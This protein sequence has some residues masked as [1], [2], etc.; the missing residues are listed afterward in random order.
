MHLVVFRTM[1]YEQWRGKMLLWFL[2]LYGLARAVIDVWRGDFDQHLYVYG[3]T[4]TQL[5]CLAAAGISI[6]LLCF[7]PRSK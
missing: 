7:T 1:K 3:F 4:L 6:V 2:V 5:I